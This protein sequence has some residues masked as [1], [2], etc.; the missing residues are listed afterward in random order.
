MSFTILSL[1]ILFVF[2]W[3]WLYIEAK[4]AHIV[5]QDSPF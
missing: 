2:S 5:E 4:T 3:I 1:A